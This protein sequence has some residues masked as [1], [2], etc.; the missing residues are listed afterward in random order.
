[1]RR[2]LRGRYVGPIHSSRKA[3]KRTP[4]SARGSR[5]T[6]PHASR[7]FGPPLLDVP[8]FRQSWMERSTKEAW[9]RLL[10]EA[11]RELPDATV[12]T[13]LEPAVP[14]ALDDGRLIVG[15][16]DQFAVEWNESKH[17]TVLAR[18][19]ER[20]FGRPTAVVFRVQEDRQQ[21]PQMDFFVAP[22]E[23][24]TVDRSGVPTTPLNER[25]EE[26]TSELQSRGH[27][28]CRLLL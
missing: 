1:M 7:T 3:G 28:V 9:K 15:A 10:D 22:R 4:A 23:P 17:A 18:A 26:H 6:F 20:V 11:R 24:A 13:W 25:S 16:P 27:L 14:I 19:A 5:L 2:R 21:R 12:R 8:P